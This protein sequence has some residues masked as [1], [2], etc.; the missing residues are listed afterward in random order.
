VAFNIFWQKRYKLLT[1]TSHY[2]S[3]TQ[4]HILKQLTD[5]N[6][7]LFMI[8]CMLHSYLLHDHLS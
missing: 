3:L 8:L 6:N 5:K 4:K 7:E 2:G 1:V